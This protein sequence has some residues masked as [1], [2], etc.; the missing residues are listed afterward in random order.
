MLNYKWSQ[1]RVNERVGVGGFLDM[2]GATQRSQVRCAA[3]RIH[4]ASQFGSCFGLVHHVVIR[5]FVLVGRIGVNLFEIAIA[6]QNGLGAGVRGC[7]K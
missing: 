1:I 7:E 5:F 3:V 6:G 2:T 4:I